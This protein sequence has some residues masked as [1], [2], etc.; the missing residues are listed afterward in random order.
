M[1]MSFHLSLCLS[2]SLSLSLFLS[3]SL[4][5]LRMSFDLTGRASFKDTV[6]IELEHSEIANNIFNQGRLRE[7]D[8][9]N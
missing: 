2:V 8:C 6:G 1:S 7:R 9:I 4:L 3:P 5:Y